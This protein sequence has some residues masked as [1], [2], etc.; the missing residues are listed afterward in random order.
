MSHL[1]EVKANFFIP[2]WK[3]SKKVKTRNEREREGEKERERLV[4]CLIFEIV[5]SE[6]TLLKFEF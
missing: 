1:P 5:D 4:Y 3:H 6:A 2:S